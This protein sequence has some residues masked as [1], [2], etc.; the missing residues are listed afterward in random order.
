M[1][2]GRSL[3]TLLHGSPAH[4]E[5]TG[6]RSLGGN[7]TE[8]A[9]SPRGTGAPSGSSVPAM[10]EDKGNVGSR[11]PCQLTNRVWAHAGYLLVLPEAKGGTL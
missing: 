8:D 9:H 7:G 6:D 1:W 5:Y 11:Y 4:S 2:L 10:V 3:L